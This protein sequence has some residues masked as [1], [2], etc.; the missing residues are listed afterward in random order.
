MEGDLK[1]RCTKRL[2]IGLAIFLAYLSVAS[3]GYAI[4]KKVAQTGMQFLS[5]DQFA[6]PAAI[7]GAYIMVGKG[8]DATFY[9]PAG[10]S[11]MQTDYDFI[12]ST[13]NWIADISY[14]A[15]AVAKNF[16]NW[17]VL[18]INYLSCN[19]G[20][21][22]GTQVASTQE[23]FIETGD[24]D[25]GSY[26]IGVSYGRKLTNKFMVG[27]QIKYAYQHL[28][29]N[30]IEEGG[31]VFQN[32]VG[33]FA[34]DFGTIFYPGFKSF[35]LGM[36]IRNFSPQ[37]KYEEEAFQLPLTFRIGFAMDVMDLMGEFSNHSL[38]IAIDALHPRAY[39]ERLN[40][41]VEYQYANLIALR[42]GYKSNYDEE[43]L[44]VGFGINPTIV[45]INF[46]LDYSYSQLGVFNNVN[47]ITIGGSF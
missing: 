34:Y 25:V 21:I 31:D 16:G 37:F 42:A 4:I 30:I 43:G 23:G 1:M 45:G 47:R 44:S 7:G 2:L 10:L 18:G 12:A 46:K 20:K 22:I 36:S 29:Q 5:V 9:N 14:N 17:G 32:K 41:G 35:R 3:P 27:G 38:L 8:A 15:G 11:D 28:G 39:T 6:R 40:I 24:L 13:T 26:A 33:G 19:Y